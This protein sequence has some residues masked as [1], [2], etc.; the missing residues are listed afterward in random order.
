MREPCVFERL[1]RR[2]RF[3]DFWI[4]QLPDGLRYFVDART[5]GKVALI[6]VIPPSA[7]RKTLLLNCESFVG[8]LQPNRLPFWYSTV[9]LS[10]AA[11][12][13]TPIGP[14]GATRWHSQHLPSDLLQFEKAKPAR[15]AGRKSSADQCRSP[16]G[17]ASPLPTRKRQRCASN[18]RSA[19][20]AAVRRERALRSRT[21]HPADV[22]FYTMM[23]SERQF[24]GML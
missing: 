23:R 2:C 7:L 8:Q 11:R 13:P 24:A 20:A 19:T 15:D 12:L 3:L 22:F 16:G 14:I 1:F 21:R 6:L 18:R 5:N 9:P 17:L 4:R 10:Y